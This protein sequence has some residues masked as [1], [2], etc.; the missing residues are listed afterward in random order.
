MY[1]DACPDADQYMSKVKN[2]L[3]SRSEPGRTWVP[4]FALL[5]FAALVA[6]MLIASTA[7]PSAF[8]SSAQ[9]E[10]TEATPTPTPTTDPDIP[11]DVDRPAG[12]SSTIGSFTATGSFV[13]QS[14]GTWR[15]QWEHSMDWTE[16]SCSSCTI[17]GYRFRLYTPSGTRYYSLWVD[18]DEDTE[19][20]WRVSNRAI[21][22][23][24][25]GRYR[26]FIRAYS[27]DGSYRDSNDV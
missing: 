3:R 10:T 13:Y 27:S 11:P 18:D 7:A 1:T 20:T 6:S 16:P 8:N 14:E 19:F 15:Y 2:I 17:N 26:S 25:T 24:G 23:T 12:Q 5:L 21:A 22:G 4:G 9:G